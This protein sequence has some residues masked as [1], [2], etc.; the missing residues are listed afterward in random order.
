MFRLWNKYIDKGQWSSVGASYRV[1]MNAIPAVLLLLLW[2]N[3]NKHFKHSE[4]WVWIAIASIGS[5]F[6]VGIASTAIDRINL[7]LAP[8]QLYFWTRLPMLGADLLTRTLI[9]IG[10]ILFYGVILW[11]WLH[12]AENLGNWVPYKSILLS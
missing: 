5:V 10:T 7:Y 6:F 4:I 11:L 1:W 2:R 3:W 8:I 9:I 12:L